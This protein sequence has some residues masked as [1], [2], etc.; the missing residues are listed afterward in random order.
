MPLK[1]RYVSLDVLRGMTVAFMCIV[2]NPGSWSHIF[3]PLQHA[4]WVGCTPTDLVFPFFLFCVG[5]A[6]AFSLRKFEG[7]DGKAYKHIIKR[8]ILIFLVGFA[9]NLFPFFPATPHDPGWSFGQNYLYWFQHKRI[10]G[11]L[12]GI[13]LAYILGGCLVVWLKKPWRLLGAVGV[14]CAAYTAILLIFGRE[15]GPFTI[16]GNVS[17]RIDEWLVGGNHCYHG[18]SGTNFDPEGLLGTM[19]RACNALLGYL[20]GFMILHSHKDRD[21]GETA[22]SDDPA[23]LSVV[24][25]MLFYGCCCLALAMALSIWIPI[26]KPLWSAS[27]VFYAGGWAMLV[28]GC[29]A[30]VIDIKGC[31]RGFVPFKAMGMNALTAFVLSGVLA[32]TLSL[33]GFS[34]SKYFGANEYASLAYALIFAFVIFCIQ[35]VLYKKKIIIKL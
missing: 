1:K 2:N 23:S 14:L 35:W 10:F 6:M 24:S 13:G 29:L 18:Y 17:M 31:E 9:L 33:F 21:V 7:D 32:K 3:P 16:E 12:Q 28:L 5:C 19:T 25:R 15:P 26:S 20:V 8:G 30:W 34:P 22:A 4:D 11:V 27:Y